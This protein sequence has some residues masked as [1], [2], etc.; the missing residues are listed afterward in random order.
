MG[1]EEVKVVITAD[2]R[3]GRGL[4]SAGKKVRGL[5]KD[6]SRLAKTLGVGLVA[7]LGAV[8]LASKKAIDKFVVQ[9]KA[10]ARLLATTKNVLTSFQGFQEGSV[11]LE[12]ELTRVN[13]ALK[14]QAKE[15]QKVTTFG[16]EQIVSAQAMASTFALNVDQVQKLTPRILDMAAAMEK[17]TGTGVDLE[18]ITI[19]LG[20]AMTTGVGALTRYGVVVSDAARASFELATEDEKLNII[21]GELDKNFK[22]VAE[23]AGDTAAGKM[24]QMSNAVGDL[25][26]IFGG[27]LAE[28]LVP[29]VQELTKFAQDEATQQRIGEIAKS[30]G[31]LATVVIPIMIDAFK[32]IASFV[33]TFAGGMAALGDE[34]IAVIDTIWDLIDSIRALAKEGGGGFGGF[35]RGATR[36]ILGFAEGGV[37]PGPKGAAQLAVVHGGE[38]IVPTHRTGG[39]GVGNTV[40]INNPVLLDDLMLDRLYEEIGR[41]MRHDVRI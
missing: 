10:E 41:G 12:R 30:M 14:E 37:V 15:L 5:N 13:E 19:A 29:F 31:E 38:T 32:G 3:T 26:E 8:A 33:S 18:Q 39:M 22:G 23:A 4:G 9:E 40:I 16:D 21:L 28:A 34:I 1:R 7:A 27:A 36:K 17:S 6:V 11:E 25:Q 2:D 20:K 35:V 24:K